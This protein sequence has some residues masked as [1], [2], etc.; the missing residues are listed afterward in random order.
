[1]STLGLGKTIKVGELVTGEYE[2]LNSPLVSIVGV[3][4][5]RAMKGKSAGEEEEEEGEETASE[6]TTEGASEE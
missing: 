6:A 3:E 2:I 4:I 1:V 5:P